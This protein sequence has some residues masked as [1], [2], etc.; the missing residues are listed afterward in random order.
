MPQVSSQAA[1]S[2]R[3]A[4]DLIRGLASSSWLTVQT[5]S[6]APDQVRGD[7]RWALLRRGISGS[8]LGNRLAPLFKPT[9][10]NTS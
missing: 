9:A 3:V 1:L 4:P 10:P 2:I 5:K 6:P 7:E 8:R